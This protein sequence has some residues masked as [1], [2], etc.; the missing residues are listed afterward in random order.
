MTSSSSGPRQP[1]RS[2]NMDLSR[3]P[4]QP[5]QEGRLLEQQFGGGI[6]ARLGQERQG[7]QRPEQEGIGDAIPPAGDRQRIERLED[8]Q[9]DV[10][11]D[12]FIEWPRGHRG[13]HQRPLSASQR[14]QDGRLVLAKPLDLHGAPP[15]CALSYVLKGLSPI[16]CRWAV[17][18][19]W[20]RLSVVP[21]CRDRVDHRGTP[22]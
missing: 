9:L 19:Y 4:S 22:G 7:R 6:Q 11:G 2:T 15:W 14:I 21:E 8:P 17:P 13:G 20:D 16:V 10:Q 3:R 12:Q 18:H 5:E 1:T